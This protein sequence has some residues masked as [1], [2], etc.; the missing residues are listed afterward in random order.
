MFGSIHHPQLGQQNNPIALS[1]SFSIFPCS[2]SIENS[3]NYL[4]TLYCLSRKREEEKKNIGKTA[5][6]SIVSYLEGYQTGAVGRGIDLPDG[7]SRMKL[8][9]MFF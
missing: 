8:G 1:L 5:Q 4:S 3:F 9:R 7:G 6:S 2:L